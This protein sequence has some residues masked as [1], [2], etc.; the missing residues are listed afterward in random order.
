MK[1]LIAALAAATATLPAGAAETCGG[2]PRLAA[3]TPPGFCV[4][5]LAEGLKFP[6]GVLPLPNGDILVADMGNWE[7]NQGS[8]WRLTKTATGYDKTQVMKKLDRPNGIVQ[9]PDG[10]VY[11]GVIHRVF[12]FDPRNPE[13]TLMDV[14]GGASKV[15]PLPGE[16]RHLLTTMRFGPDNNLYVNIGSRTDHCESA[17]GKAPDAAKSCLEAEGKEPLGAIRAYEMTWPAGAIK[18]WRTYASG[19]RNSMAL[20]FHPA[21]GKLWQA[22]NSRDAINAAMPQLKN[23][24]DLPHDE[25]NLIEAGQ[26]YGWPYCYDNNLASPEYPGAKCA[27]YRAPLRLLPAHA[28]PLGMVFYTA[29]RFPE[30]YRNSLIIGYH[31]YR[32]QGHRLVALLPD[33]AGQPLGKSVDLITGWVRKGKQGPGAPVDVKLGPDGFIYMADDHNGTV[34]RL[35]YEEGAK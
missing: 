24:N 13:G 8:L 10:L 4:A 31:G 28:A 32:A 33:K 27:G 34:L 29:R 35:Q 18:S 25:L 6:R 22:E 15:A 26:R 14:I 12:R 16:G 11:V 1:L 19:L 30:Q 7:P 17:D 21:S 5:V 20:A 9:G 2:L 3:T 23:D